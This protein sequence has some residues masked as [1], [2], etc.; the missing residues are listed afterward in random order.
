MALSNPNRH[1]DGYIAFT[2]YPNCSFKRMTVYADA[3]KVVSEYGK[4]WHKPRYPATLLDE[5]GS[6]DLFRIIERNDILFVNEEGEALHVQYTGE[7]G[8]ALAILTRWK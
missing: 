8:G 4:V 5:E 2:V 1:D 3:G 6:G 7:A